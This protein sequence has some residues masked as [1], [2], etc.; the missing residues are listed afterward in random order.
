MYVIISSCTALKDDSVPIP[1][2]SR[3]VEPHHYL[4]E[5][6]LSTFLKIRRRILSDPRARLGQRTTYA[7]DLY[8]RAGRA[9]KD[10]FKNNYTKL[11][12]LLISGETLEWFFLS[13]GYGIIHALE[14][15][16]SY[17]A[18]FSRAIAQQNNI[19]YTADL[20]RNILPQICDSILSKTKCDYV[21]I[22]GSRDYTS[23]I[24][25]TKFWRTAE[26]IKIFES[27]GSAGPN[28]LSPIICDLVGKILNGDVATFN[29]KY[30]KFTKQAK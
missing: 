24:K 27:S 3:T 22:F 4:E 8:T 11:K 20:W 5:P 9:Y 12:P 25:E 13:G 6:L 26:N 30:G 1:Q 29:S 7:L 2:N 18:T 14:E 17:Q 10:T 15:A 23:F 19:P 16:R 28:W 21:Y